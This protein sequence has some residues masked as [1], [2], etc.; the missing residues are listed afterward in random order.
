MKSWKKRWQD[1]LDAAVPALSDEVK[2][3]PIPAQERVEYVAFA[4]AAPPKQAW[5]TQLFSTPRRMVSCLSACALALTMVG[6]SVYFALREDAP[7]TAAEVV[8]VEV[9][10]QA[11]F[12][13]DENGK[14]TAVVALN[15]DADI[16]LSENR[17]LEMEGK[18]VEEAVTLF[19]DYTAQLGFLDLEN[20]DAVRITSCVENGRLDEIGEG[21][22][23]YFK[24][25]GSYIAVAEE[26]LD[27]EAFCQRVNMEVI[28]TVENLKKSVERIPA[29][30]FEREAEGK[31][32]ADLQAAYRENIPMEAVK[33]MFASTVSKGVEKIEMLEAIGVLSDEILYH[34]DNPGFFIDRDY[35]SIQNKQIPAAMSEIMAQMQEK[36]L[37]YERNYGVKIESLADLTAELLKCSAT[38]LQTLTDA[39]L[40]YTIELFEQNFAMV[41]GILETLGIDTSKLEAFY[42]LPK[43]IEEYRQK[44]EEYTKTRYEDLKEKNLSIYEKERAALSEADY[45]AY[46]SGLIE[47][48]GSL[49]KYFEKGA[50]KN[51][52]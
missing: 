19:V 21:L 38:A 34:E 6:T 47:E 11:M 13:V 1:E 22:K 12:S 46:L 5:Y 3:M 41:V 37:A 51:E 33:E 32:A 31:T 29:L 18:T 7:L 50:T 8:S 25:M 43:T 42:E 17:Y 45:E 20:P 14:V 48:Y 49:S 2:N 10:P 16:V 44:I 30:S 26:T 23:N 27:M 39:L 36:L 40:N 24:N 52:L 9:N 28:D 15:N 35:W 4:E